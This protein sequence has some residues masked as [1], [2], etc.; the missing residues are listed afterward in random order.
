MKEQIAET[1]TTETITISRA[2]YDM[3]KG[4]NAELNQ[5]VDWLMEQLRL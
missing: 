3:L 4:E 1:R 2:E 5:K